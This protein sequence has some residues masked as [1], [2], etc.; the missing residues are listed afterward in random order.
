MMRIPLTSTDACIFRFD[1]RTPFP[2]CGG[3][4]RFPQ[5]Y[6]SQAKAISPKRWKSS[7]NR[8]TPCNKPAEGQPPGA[9]GRKMHL[10]AFFFVKLWKLDE[11][12]AVFTRCSGTLQATEQKIH[13][14][15]RE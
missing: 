10:P 13:G 5:T 4:M 1:Y 3:R 2:R 7:Q 15:V 14:G 6:I 8:K 12:Q 9:C 11:H